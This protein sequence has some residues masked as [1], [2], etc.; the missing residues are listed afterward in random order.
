MS[1]K[2]ILHVITTL[3]IILGCGNQQNSS[4][5]DD[6]ESLVSKEKYDSAY[7]EIL[8]IEPSF[9]EKT[10]FQA[11]FYLLLTQ[12]SLLTNHQTT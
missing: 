10:E 5:L 1:K 12:T 2:Y 8:N 9:R 11:H 7:Q 3:L 6:I 4:I